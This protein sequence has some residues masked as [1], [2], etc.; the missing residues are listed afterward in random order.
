MLNVYPDTGGNITYTT[1]NGTKRTIKKA[2]SAEQWMEEANSKNA[3]G[4]GA[5]QIDIDPVTLATFNS[6][7]N[8]H[9]K[10]ADGTWKYDVVFFGSWIGKNIVLTVTASDAHT[11]VKSITLP[12]GTVVQKNAGK[13]IVVTH[14][15]TITKNGSYTFTVTDMYDN[16]I[17]QTIVVSKIDTTVPDGTISTNTTNW[18]NQDVI[19]TVTATDNA[20]G[21]KTITLPGG[22]VLNV[23]KTTFNATKNGSYSFVITDIV[24]NNKTVTIVVN[25]IDKVVPTEGTATIGAN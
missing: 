16:T 18:T 17:S 2:G 8:G 4:F 9:L 22:A 7:P 25:N 1:W 21:V 20:S 14:T 3:K 19:L 23:A 11:G 12:D 6:N 15:Y 5:G 24:G 13:G 10:N